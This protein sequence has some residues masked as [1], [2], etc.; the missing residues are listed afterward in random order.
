M[1]QQTWSV[2]FC[3][4]EDYEDYGSNEKCTQIDWKQSL[5]F[6]LWIY[7]QRESEYNYIN[8]LH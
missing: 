5:D 4:S 6:E 3:I 7:F 1:Y 8:R 2:R